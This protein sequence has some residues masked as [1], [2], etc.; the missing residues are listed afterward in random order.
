MKRLAEDH[1][2]GREEEGSSLPPALP[3]GQPVPQAYLPFA[4]RRVK[5][6]FSYLAVMK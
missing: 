4:K 5:G 3:N 6:S 1:V 2:A